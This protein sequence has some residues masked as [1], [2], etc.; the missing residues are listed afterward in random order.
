MK[1]SLK[2]GLLGLLTGATAFAGAL[3]LNAQNTEV[4]SA[5]S[6]FTMEMEKGASVRL[7]GTDEKE[8][9]I[10]Y[11]AKLASC[12]T[13]AK[14]YVMII[15]TGWLTK[16]NLSASY[17]A[18][19]DYY[20]TLSAQT[21]IAS[22]IMTME[23]TPQY[24]EDEDCYYFEGS[25]KTVKYE[26]SFRE[27]FGIAYSEK[28]G[29]RTY[30]E[31]ETGENVR[32]V[33]QVASAAL[34][35]KTENWTTDQKASLK[36]MVKTAYNASLD[37]DY[38][39]QEEAELPTI[40]AEKA[41]LPLLGGDT[42]QMDTLTGVSALENIGV[43]VQYTSSSPA[44]VTVSESGMLSANTVGSGATITATV[45]GEDYEV[46]EI[47]PVENML[48]GFDTKESEGNILQMNRSG[49][50]YSD[51]FISEWQE[52]FEGRNGV[53]KTKTTDTGNYQMSRVQPKF[54]KT[55]A[56]LAAI[57][58]DYI[59]I[60]VW[61]DA[62]GT[63]DT[64]SG[65]Y[66]GF[67]K[68]LGKQWQTV[69]ITKEDIT[70]TSPQSTY[71]TQQSGSNNS[72]GYFNTW[73]GSDT[74]TATSG[75]Y[76]FH[77]KSGTS[78]VNSAGLTVYFDSISYAKF[79]GEFVAPTQTGAFTLPTVTMAGKAPEISVTTGSNKLTVDGYNTNLL[80]AGDYTV[81]YTYNYNGLSYAKEFNFTVDRPAFAEGMLEDFAIPSTANNLFDNNKNPSTWSTEKAD[82]NGET[83]TGVT[84]LSFATASNTLYFKAPFT[85]QQILDM[86]E[87]W[88][89]LS[90]MVLVESE[91]V[92]V[93]ANITLGQW[94]LSKSV[95]NKVWTEVK[96]TKDEINTSKT[97]WGAK[98]A[99]YATNYGTESGFDVFALRHYNGG[100]GDNLFVLKAA[101]AIYVDEIKFVK[102][103]E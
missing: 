88:D 52:S 17:D 37:S 34:N 39:S 62:E 33:S 42:H 54:N 92:A 102:N 2:I 74:A 3:S 75:G 15:P 103:A 83:K 57:D 70:R 82:S 16:Y 51:G 63:F 73:Y 43:K 65:N 76:L 20:G 97:V 40:S 18:D 77:I 58:F 101:G 55:K 13:E 53:V 10:K 71:W 98:I 19:C 8:Y 35:D 22:R 79:D 4:V 89:Y 66:R 45:L 56:E 7:V 6:N 38:T 46:A 84:M 14:Y 90:I 100:T 61:I 36:K 11:T 23:A 31:F 49:I 93:N 30:A 81:A 26:N 87:D 64:G 68:I 5:D 72:R 91:S 60:D 85:R 48:V 44:Q 24:V 29:T 21:E 32:S 67:G 25:I 1:K 95:K 78:G 99:A 27:Y 80:Y 47:A 86:G 9:G 94:N 12:D 96:F 41:E 59:A 28:N 69:I 50:T